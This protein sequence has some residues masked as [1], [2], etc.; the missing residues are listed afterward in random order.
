MDVLGNMLPAVLVMP[1]S[2]SLDNF[3]V[4]HGGYFGTDLFVIL[5]EKW[6]LRTEKYVFNALGLWVFFSL[7]PFSIHKRLS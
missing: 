2:D 3:F 1:L 6:F 7:K 5:I 4:T